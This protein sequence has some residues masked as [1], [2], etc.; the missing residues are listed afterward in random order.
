MNG[1]SW[2]PNHEPPHEREKAG[3]CHIDK[4]VEEGEGQAGEGKQPLTREPMLDTC[5]LKESSDS[6][7]LYDHLGLVAQVKRTWNLGTC[8]DVS[9]TDCTG[10]TCTS[11]CLH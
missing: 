6:V 4:T 11:C 9:A 1:K 8:T 3:T 7:K 10:K 2:Q 5:M